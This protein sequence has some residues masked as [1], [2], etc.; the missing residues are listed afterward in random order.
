MSIEQQ[1]FPKSILANLNTNNI[2]INEQKAWGRLHKQNKVL[3][4]LVTEKY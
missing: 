2:D 4:V 1:K 3:S